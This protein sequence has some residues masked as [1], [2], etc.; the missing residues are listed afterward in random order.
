MVRG[1]VNN[2]T[3]TS[4]RTIASVRRIVHNSAS[5]TIGTGEDCNRDVGSGKR[6]RKRECIFYSDVMSMRSCVRQREG[7]APAE[8]S[9]ASGSAGASP[10]HAGA[11][12]DDHSGVI[13]RVSTASDE[14]RGFTEFRGSSVGLTIPLRSCQA[15]RQS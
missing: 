15:A 9:L 3:D 11:C 8:P 13:L 7:V 6:I 2:C 12:S 10:S 4:T 1:I 14:I 5:H